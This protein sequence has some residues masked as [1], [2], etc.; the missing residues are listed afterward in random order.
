MFDS[1]IFRLLML[2]MAGAGGSLLIVWL[3]EIAHKLF[4]SKPEK[5]E[6][7]PE[8]YRYNRWVESMQERNKEVK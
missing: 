8:E 7:S 4:D 3:V 2:Y 6:I 5:N 1:G